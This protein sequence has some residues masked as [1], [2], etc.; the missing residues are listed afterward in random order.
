[1]SDTNLLLDL[2]PREVEIVRMALRAQEER[3]KK[4]GFPVL[5]IEISILRAKIADALLDSKLLVG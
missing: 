5:V 4:D 3:H 1:M 2:T